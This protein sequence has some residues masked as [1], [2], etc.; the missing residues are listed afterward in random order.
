MTNGNVQ[1]VLGSSGNRSLC[2]PAFDVIEGLDVVANAANQIDAFCHG[3]PS[4][5]APTGAFPLFLLTHKP[6]QTFMTGT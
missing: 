5:S 1:F 2:N 4:S 3:V 6:A